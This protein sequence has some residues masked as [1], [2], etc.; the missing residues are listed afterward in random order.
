MPDLFNTP[1]AGINSLVT[2]TELA[3]ADGARLVGFTQTGTPP[4]GT[5]AAKLRQIISVKDA[6]FNAVGDAA[7]DDTAAIQNAINAVS[8][9]GGI[10][11]L[12]PGDYRLSSGISITAS[13][14]TLQGAGEGATRL[15]CTF[16]S[17][18]IVSIGDGTVN[19]N[20]CRVCHLSITS[21]ISKVSGGAIVMR[22]AFN[23]KADHFRLES[24][25]YFGVVV[26]GGAGQFINYIDTFFIDSG[27]Q[28]IVLS[29]DG[30]LPQDVFIQ[31]GVIS[32][33]T[34]AA[35][36]MK[37]CSGVYC[38][39]LDLLTCGRGV[40]TFPDAG[41]RVVA[42]FMNG[43]IADTTVT[44]GWDLITNGGLL[45]NWMM[46]NC[47]AS[48]CGFGTGGHGVR[49][50]PGSG[51]ATG[52][53]VSNSHIF[54]N[55]GSGVFLGTN[56]RKVAFSNCQI[57][58]NSV[59]GSSSFDGVQVAAGVSDWSFEGGTIGSGGL[60]PTNNQRYGIFINSGASN[61]Y[62]IVSVDLS[63]NIAGG[64]SDG[65]SGATKYIANNIGFRTINQ[66]VATIGATQTSVNVN[67]GLSVDFDIIDVH[68]TP[69][70]DV[71]ERWWVEKVSAG[72]FK[73]QLAS[74]AA[75]NRT[76]SWSVRT[77]G[78]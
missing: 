16:E 3:S 45:A 43:V 46:V 40:L 12:P 49:L 70:G 23:C 9:T 44:H 17:G 57:L 53:A 38:S 1:I 66:G 29:R 32:N 72:V 71:P 41:Q 52:F 35:V 63:G 26:D 21:T 4:S 8:A 37:H 27:Y 65:G 6:P 18:D 10:V 5:V 50:A 77:K 42:V 20:N 74:A 39:Y 67:A 11:F 2:K 69:Q 48:S 59:D 19:P 30:T 62:K 15:I 56:T 33:C 34:D 51:N 73:V 31:N 25:M 68:V 58:T 60:F 54:N 64:L 55:G 47:W 13:D 76:F 22:N 75:S 7:A 28:G 36:F 14:V 78:A 61:N 24:N